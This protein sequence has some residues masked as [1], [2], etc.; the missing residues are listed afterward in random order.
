[1]FSAKIVD[2]GGRRGDAMQEL[3]Q[4]RHPVASSEAMDVLHQ[5]MRPAWHRRIHMVIEIVVVLPAFF[6][7]IL[8]LATTIS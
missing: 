3:A 7:S 2:H 1:V 5:A 6:A 8:L 4:W